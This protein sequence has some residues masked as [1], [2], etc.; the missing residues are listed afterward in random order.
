MAKANLN[1]YVKKITAKYL[2]AKE[3]YMSI[4][5]QIR[6]ENERYKSVDQDKYSLQGRKELIIEHDAIIRPLRAEMDAIRAQFEYDAREIIKESDK[7]FNRR[8][9]YTPA[10]IDNNGIT[11]LE[12]GNLSDAEVMQMADNYL[13]AGNSTMYFLCADKLNASDDA[14]CR[15]Y[16]SQAIK[17]RNDREDHKIL[18]SVIGICSAGLRTETTMSRDLDD[19]IG[20]SEM[21]NNNMEN[22]LSNYIKQAD[23]IAVEYANPWE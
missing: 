6:R 13:Q 5:D 7:I 22:Y 1:H 10:D 19:G 23:A 4:V 14:N 16:Y 18:N 20:A 9:C 11:I 8:Y 3:K 12:K 15:T 17:M 21:I 2:L